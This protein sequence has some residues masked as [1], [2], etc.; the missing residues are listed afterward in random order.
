M[1]PET[2]PKTPHPPAER[3]PRLWAPG[4]CC[5]VLFPG[6]FWNLIPS[7]PGMQSLCPYFLTLSAL[8]GPLQSTLQ[9]IMPP[10]CMAVDSPLTICK[11]LW[12]TQHSMNA[13]RS[14]YYSTPL[15]VFSFV[16]YKHWAF[17][18][19][20]LNFISFSSPPGYWNRLLSSTAHPTHCS[21]GH[22]EFGSV[23]AL[24]HCQLFIL[25]KDN[26]GL[27]T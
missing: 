10:R 12:R 6:G 1:F 20:I 25:I 2:T 19:G 16:L 3:A 18:S 9:I 15:G 13:K 8:P 14:P 7:R 26:I 17:T 23:K 24:Y 5:A 22:G 11:D 4:R 27:G 21:P